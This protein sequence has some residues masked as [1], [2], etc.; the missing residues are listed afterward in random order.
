MICRNPAGKPQGTGAKKWSLK[1]SN[2]QGKK[3]IFE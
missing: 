2:N 1:N 3:K